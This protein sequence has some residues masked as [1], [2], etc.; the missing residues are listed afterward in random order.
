MRLL[1][2]TQGEY[3]KRILANI[4]NRGPQSWV[5]DEWEAPRVLPPIVDYPEDFIPADLGQHD[6]I[7]ALP[8]HAGLGQL[9]PDLAAATGA[10]SLIA[11]VDREEWLPKGLV[12]QVRRWLADAGVAAVFPKPFCTLTEQSYNWGKGAIA[13]D[14]PLI[15][16]FARHFGQPCFRMACVGQEIAEVE[17]VRDAPCGCS[18]FVAENLAGIH[19]DEA[20]QAAGLLHHHYPCLASMGIDPEF[21]DTIMHISGRITKEAV[22]AEVAPVKTPTRYLEPAG[23]SG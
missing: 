20:E 5:V 6:L 23:R 1:I 16:E 11:P 21:H 9:L 7:L 14:A 19:A 13:Y 18:A 4:R 10:R 15:A 12:N 22:E 3:G 17:V 8:E 2:V